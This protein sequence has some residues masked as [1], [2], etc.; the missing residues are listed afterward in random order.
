MRAFLFA[1]AAVALC[2]LGLATSAFQQ[3]LRAPGVA[4]TTR[5]RL[6]T[7]NCYA[8]ARG[9]DMRRVR[10][11]GSSQSS[12]SVAAKGLFDSVLNA[13]GLGSQDKFI[14]PMAFYGLKTKTLEGNPFDFESLKGKTVLITNVASK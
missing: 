14:S 10:E 3:S 12:R 11:H 7:P 8:Y 1:A 4:V 13:V 6:I 2:L 9:F 5:S